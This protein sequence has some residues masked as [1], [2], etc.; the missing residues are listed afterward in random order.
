MSPILSCTHGKAGG[1]NCEPFKAAEYLGRLMAAIST[2]WVDPNACHQLLGYEYIRELLFHRD[3]RLKHNIQAPRNFVPQNSL[4]TPEPLSQWLLRF[5]HWW[6]PQPRLQN[7]WA[8]LQGTYEVIDTKI[9]FDYPAFSLMS[10]FVKQLPKIIT[11]FA[12]QNLTATLG[13]PDYVILVVPGSI[14]L[15]KR[16]LLGSTDIEIFRH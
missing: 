3:Q 14:L 16:Q 4:H 7:I 13:N 8:G 11:Q 10:Q 15:S 6:S 9:T 5:Y 2:G 12:I 1:L